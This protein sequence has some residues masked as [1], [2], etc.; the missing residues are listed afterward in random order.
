MIPAARPSSHLGEIRGLLLTAMAVFAV[1]VFIGVLNG[2]DLMTFNRETL[3]AH[4]HA[5]T[6]G[7]ISLS[8]F[9]ACLWLFGASEGAPTPG[10]RTI[11]WLTWLSVISVPLYVAAFWTGNY[12]FRAVTSVPMLLAI[13]GFLAW[14]I[15]RSRQLPLNVPRLAMLAGM[16]I[17]TVG[18]FFGTLIQVQ[19]ALSFTLVESASA[20]SGHVTAMAFGYLVLVGMGLVEWRLA[21]PSDRLTRGGAVQVAS[22]FIG[23]I[24]LTVGA[25]TGNEVMLQ[26]NTLFQLIAVVIFGV[27]MG[28]FVV[29]APWLTDGSAR[30]FAAAGVFVAVDIALLLFLIVQLLSG[31]YGP[32]T[33]DVSLLKIPLWMIFALDHAIFIGVMSNAIFGLAHDLSH[34]HADTWRWAD[35]VVFWGMNLG[36]VGFV[37]GLALDTALVKQ[38]FSPVMGV[39]IG[40]GL[41]A[42]W[43]RV[44]RVEAA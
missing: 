33:S 4:V 28:G 20:L 1:T 12:P 22:L 24:L 13:I 38:I 23:S 17:L 14:T 41:L 2:L 31:A 39:A 36:L 3:M 18:G 43:Q 9:A 29:R 32:I 30:Y 11:G 16:L 25:L 6:L 8:V 34:D 35:Q 27:R 37:L 10:E 42:Y 7:W 21:P 40:V 26:L 19:V 5:G 44:R 15:G